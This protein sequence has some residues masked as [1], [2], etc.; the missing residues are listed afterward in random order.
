MNEPNNENNI[1]NDINNDINDNQ[2]P[3]IENE[4][5]NNNNINNENNIN[6]N[7]NNEK[8]YYPRKPHF[9]NIGS[10][11]VICNK[12]VMGAKS[13]IGVVIL[14]IVCELISFAAFVVFNQPYFPFYIYII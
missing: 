6:N 8:K 5:N 1:N 2:I 4:I 3:N 11:L 10:N 13:G 12:Y 7:A 14:M 9:G